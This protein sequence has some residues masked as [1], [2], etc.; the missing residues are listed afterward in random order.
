MG[1]RLKYILFIVGFLLLL[2]AFS[3]AVA[4]KHGEV[5]NITQVR[6]KMQALK[7]ER[8]FSLDLLFSGDSESY[9]AF[10]SLQLW[11]EQGI[12]SYNLGAS[13]LRLCD[14]Y[15]ILC[16][17]G[18]SQSP[19]VVMLET[20][21]IMA[22]SG[23]HKDEED[24]LTNCVE[25]L[26]PIFHYHI[27]YKSYLPE[28]IR[29]KD[30]YWK[31]AHI[32]KGFLVEKMVRPYLGSDYMAEDKRLSPIPESSLFYLNGIKDYC[33]K[34]RISL[35][36]VSAPSAATWNEGKH[37][38]VAAWAKENDIPYLDLNL[39]TEELDLDWNEDTMDEGNH[40]NFSGSEKVTKYIGEYLRNNYALEDHR[41]DEDYEDWEINREKAGLYRI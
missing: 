11:A 6:M 36:L 20:D 37:E 7:A 35:I 15:E 16:E 4:P 8:P 26:F 38:A 23:T 9:R 24:I 34:K 32:L 39:L 19:K 28:A 25:D 14:C 41:G 33:A 22:E 12:P 17:S 31:D 40:V 21:A 2:S 1:N 13:A 30:L 29:K 27:F 3:Y 18:N 10:S 5:Y